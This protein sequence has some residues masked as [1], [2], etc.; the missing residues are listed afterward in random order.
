LRSSRIAEVDIVLVELWNEWIE[1][2][3]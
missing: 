1:R 3:R 2:E